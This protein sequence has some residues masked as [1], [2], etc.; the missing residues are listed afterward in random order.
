MPKATSL[1][2]PGRDTGARTTIASLAVA[3]PLQHVRDIAA[4]RWIGKE[5]VAQCRCFDIGLDRQ[6]ENI[7]HFFG[8][9]AQ[10]MC[11]E[12]SFG[13]FLDQDFVTGGPFSD[14]SR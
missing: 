1:A 3:V 4:A 12:D 9:L 14:P 5:H 11:S 13:T 2:Q 10:K 7:D 6:G 8:V